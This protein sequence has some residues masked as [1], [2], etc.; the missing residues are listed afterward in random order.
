MKFWHPKNAGGTSLWR[1]SV[2][3][4]ELSMP[5]WKQEIS[6][7]LSSVSPPLARETEI[8]EELAQ[9]VED[10]YQDLLASGGIETQAQRTALE[11]IT[12]NEI[13]L[14]ELRRIA[15][16]VMP[17]P[18]ISPSSGKQSILRDLWQDV[19]YSL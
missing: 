1:L 19:R 10:R 8:V 18:A 4:R 13:L 14:I 3:S 16:P 12:S 2:A 9:H 11:E 5:E 15:R 17:E 6:K 7:R